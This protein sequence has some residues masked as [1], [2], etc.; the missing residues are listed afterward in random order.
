LLLGRVYNK[1]LYLRGQKDKRGGTIPQKLENC[2]ETEVSE[3]LSLKNLAKK[4]ETAS[5][6]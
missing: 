1:P 2:S 5:A 6:Q 3:Q 4:A